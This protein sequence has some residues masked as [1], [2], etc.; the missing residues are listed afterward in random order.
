MW[1]N[2]YNECFMER[3]EREPRDL[4]YQ[5]MSV[6]CKRGFWYGS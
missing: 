6:L 2:F 4:N 3:E 5:R 1:V